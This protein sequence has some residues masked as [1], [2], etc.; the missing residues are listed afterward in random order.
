MNIEIKNPSKIESFAYIFQH[1]KL[2][3]E[4]VNIM[5]E[6][7]R[8]YIQAM[9]QARVSVFE[10]DISSEWFDKYERHQNANFCLGI[11]SSILYRILNT[12]DKNQ[13]LSISYDEEESDKLTIQFTSETKSVF[14]KRFVVPLID[15]DEQIMEIPQSDSHAEISLNAANFA[16]VISQLR[17]FGDTIDITC[18]EEEILFCSNSIETGNMTVKIGMDDLD[19]FSINDGSILNISFG[20]AQLH[21]ICMYHKIAKDVKIRWIPEFPMQVSYSID[22]E[23]LKLRFYLA[24]K[25]SD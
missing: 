21:N 10:I 19:E 23:L 16:N 13:E 22:N 15:I 12:R 7:N 6:E 20:L 4:Q 18:S 9:D 17:L 3:T 11:Q 14:D 1:M 24:P 8:L 25:I 5:F 2:F